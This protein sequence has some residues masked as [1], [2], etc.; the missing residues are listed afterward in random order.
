MIE[1]IMAGKMAASPS[2]RSNRSIIQ[3]ARG[4]D[5]LLAAGGTNSL[6]SHSLRA[7]SNQRKKF[8]SAK[9]ARTSG[10]APYIEL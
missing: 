4:R 10:L 3:S 5:R 9:K 8:F 2:E 7:R 6:R 1:F